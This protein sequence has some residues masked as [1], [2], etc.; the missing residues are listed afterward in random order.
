MYR[1]EAVWKSFSYCQ[2]AELHHLAD[3]ANTTVK[4]IGNQDYW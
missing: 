3:Q 4:M 1:V 2:D